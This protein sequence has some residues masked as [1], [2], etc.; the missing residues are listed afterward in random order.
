M[1]AGGCGDRRSAELLL[2]RWL[3][4]EADANVLN[5]LGYR[6]NCWVCTVLSCVVCSVSM[7][8][9]HLVLCEQKSPSSRKLGKLALP[10]PGLTLCRVFS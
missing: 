10:G 5:V 9:Q 1:T 8:S 7:F 6:S 2:L 3:H 4:A